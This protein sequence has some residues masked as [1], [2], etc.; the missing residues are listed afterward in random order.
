MV[1]RSNQV[2]VCVEAPNPNA[3]TAGQ[4]ITIN[5]KTYKYE[6]SPNPFPPSTYNQY[7]TLPDFC[8][9][10]TGAYIVY[11]PDGGILEYSYPN[12]PIVPIGCYCHP[13]VPCSNLSV[14]KNTWFWTDGNGHW[15]AVISLNE[16]SQGSINSWQIRI[17]WSE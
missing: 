12:P 6:Y 16:S 7:P 13:G 4:Y 1:V 10:Y 17:L 3:C 11:N 15:F 5:G 8:I 9:Y 2:S 14:G